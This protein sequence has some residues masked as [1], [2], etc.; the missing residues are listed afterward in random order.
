MLRRVRSI[1]MAM[2]HLVFSFLNATYVSETITEYG[3]REA[4]ARG[5]TRNQ[6]RG[7]IQ[8]IRHTSGKE[9]FEK[10]GPTVAL[11]IHPFTERFSHVSRLLP[12]L[13][14]LFLLSFLDRLVYFSSRLDII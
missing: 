3:L 2:G 10:S 13:T 12:I 7:H 6:P 1:I 5:Q 14:L 8:R 4:S 11:R 9:A